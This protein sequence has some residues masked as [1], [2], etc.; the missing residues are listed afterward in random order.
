MPTPRPS[1]AG[2][3]P[4]RTA[5]ILLSM[6]VLAV[7]GIGFAAASEVTGN[8]KQTDVFSSLTDRPA[9]N[10][11]TNILLVGNDDRAGISKKD[12]KAWKLGS[13]DYGSHAE[14]LLIVHL[15]DDGT[16][17][18][19]SIPR[20]T[21]V[22]IPEYTTSTGHVVAATR[23]R[24]NA[25]YGIGGA[26]LTVQTIEKNTGV[27]IDH[28]AQIDFPGFVAMVDSLGGVPVCLKEDVNDAD[29]GLNLTAG[30]HSLDGAQALAYVRAR[31]FDASED[32]GRIK[33]Q[34]AF[35]GSVFTQVMSPAVLIN[36]VKLISFMDAAAGSVTTDSGF[37]RDK[38][39]ALMAQMRGVSPSN[40]TFQTVPIVP[41]DG[42]AVAWD[43]V[44]APGIF[45]TLNSGDSLSDPPKTP[46]SA[47][48]AAAIPVVE[49][50]PSSI[51]VRV[52]NGSTISGLGTQ[53]GK[54]MKAAGY[55]VVGVPANY[56]K[57]S[58]TTLIRYDPRYDVSLKTLQASLPGAKVEEVKYL[59]ST[60]QVI[61][62][63]SYKGVTPISVTGASADG[64]SGIDG[65]E[66]PT[67]AA[68]KIC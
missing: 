21:L 14:P 12:K 57:R 40:I 26:P 34:Q 30:E 9:S 20:D 43:P 50:S 13:K 67:T 24:V 64:G 51:N 53:L 52:Y 61:A 32:L 35:L 3:P 37:D 5:G 46:K 29:S 44:H 65:L 41:A 62:G 48:T 22:D 6:G 23:Q 68:D 59:G 55:S 33:R 1:T 36:P 38:M 17:G 7:S 47:S 15:S 28:Y 42:G 18:V 63:T 49:K 25:A 8:V 58:E 19:V 39:W 11:G 10:G 54:D 2:R 66:K 45:E 56:A 31:H 27:H 16:V 60:F 4:L